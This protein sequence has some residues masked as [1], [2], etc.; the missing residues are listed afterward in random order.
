[1]ETRYL[2]LEIVLDI[3]RRQITEFG[4]APGVRD[5]GLIE[6]ALLR[7]QTGYYS[8]VLEEAA[9]LWESLTMNHVF[10]DGNKRIGFA[11]TYVFLRLNGY[12]LSA[13][14]KAATEFVLGSLEKGEFTKDILDNWLR[15][16]VTEKRID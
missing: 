6:A 4:G 12:Y 9:A 14:S 3:H 16:N 8:D 1:M 11:A 15:A 5:A 13:K 7:P 10:V 2:T